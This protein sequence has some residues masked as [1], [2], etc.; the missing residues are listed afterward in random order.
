MCAYSVDKRKEE[1]VAPFKAVEDAAVVK[2]PVEAMPLMTMAAKLQITAKKKQSV[3]AELSRAHFEDKSFD[4]VQRSENKAWCY[5]TSH[6]DEELR[7]VEKQIELAQQSCRY[8]VLDACV[9]KQR[10]LNA[11]KKAL[12][13]KHD[14]DERRYNE[15]RPERERMFNETIA[16]KRQQALLHAEAAA[17]E[18]AA[19]YEVALN[20]FITRIPVARLED[21]QAE[22]QVPRTNEAIRETFHRLMMGTQLQE[23]ESLADGIKS[24]AQVL[25]GTA[26]I[27]GHVLRDL[28]NFLGAI[29]G[30]AADI[31]RAPCIA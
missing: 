1:E 17:S 10:S 8:H 20:A 24:A 13:K 15:G 30:G 22:G 29:A 23:E 18:A 14:D 12:K 9:E 21:E 27:I 25:C 26:R 19:A 2:A 16:K 11:E 7:I 28:P 5:S 3:L 4:E 6:L 31:N